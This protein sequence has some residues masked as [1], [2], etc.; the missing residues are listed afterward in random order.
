M[1]KKLKTLTTEQYEK[2][3]KATDVIAEIIAYIIPPLFIIG[4]IWT[5]YSMTSYRIK[6]EQV[7]KQQQTVIHQQDSIQWSEINNRMAKYK[8]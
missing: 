6:S 1:K 8:I 3:N 5:A 7:Y 4:L 2:F